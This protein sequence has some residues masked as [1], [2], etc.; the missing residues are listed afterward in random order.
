MK[1]E[2]SRQIFEKILKYQ[3]SWKSVQY[4]SSRSM[5][6]DGRT[7]GQTNRREEAN[8]RFSQFCESA[9]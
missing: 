7:D 4:E 3:I 8:G 2:F 1:L 6:T 9:Y 5:W